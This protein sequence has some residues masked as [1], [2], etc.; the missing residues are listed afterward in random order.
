L[1]DDRGSVAVSSLLK[2][3]MR[4]KYLLLLLTAC[5][6]P[7]PADGAPSGAQASAAESPSAGP[8]SVSPRAPPVTPTAELDVEKLRAEGR[9]T[10]SNR[11][12]PG[13]SERY[14]HAE[15]YIRA[16]LDRVRAQVT[17]FSHYKDLVP[18]KFHNARV[19]GKEKE[20]TELYLQVPI[21]HGVVMLWEVLRFGP[22]VVVEPGL[23]LLE[24]K[25]VRGN[26][27][28]A[29][30]LMTMHRIGDEESVLECDLL[31]LPKVPAPQSAIDEE[32]RDAAGQALDAIRDRA[33][34]KGEAHAIRD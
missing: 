34:K 9:A 4:A 20:D 25:H 12:P 19:L 14:G 21:M 6:P 11:Q 13:K 17:D 23:E 16:A 32:L 18:E 26:V 24:G 15:V 10:R 7:R 30:L 3:F 27:K 33:E 1:V 31:I 5:G 29:N 2:V 22:V 28:T 8:S